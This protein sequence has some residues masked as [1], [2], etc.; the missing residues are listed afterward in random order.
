MS[1][2]KIGKA[3]RPIYRARLKREIRAKLKANKDSKVLFRLNFA[4]SES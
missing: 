2:R 3:Y 4:K 1:K